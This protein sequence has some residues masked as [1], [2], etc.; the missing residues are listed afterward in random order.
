MAD[1]RPRHDLRR[2]RRMEQ[3]GRRLLGQRTRLLREHQL[4]RVVLAF[5]LLQSNQFQGDLRVQSYFGH[6]YH[7]TTGEFNFQLLQNIKQFPNWAI[8]DKLGVNYKDHNEVIKNCIRV[9]E[10]FNKKETVGLVKTHNMLF[11]FN[12]KF[13]FTNLENTLG[14]I[15]IVRDP[16]N[17]V[18]SYARHL[19]ISP[20]ETVKFMTKGKANDMFLMGNWAENFIS[21]KQFSN[22][23]KYLLIKYEDLENKKKSTLLK[24]FK[25]LQTLGVEFKFDMVKL[26]K[27]IK[28]T[29]FDK[30]KN[31]EKKEIFTESTIDPKTGKRKVFFNLGPKNDWRK[32]LDEKNR[33]IIEK[34]FQ[35]E[36]LEL[37]YLRL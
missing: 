13:P 18:L 10:S 11:N 6:E 34:N 19:K 28:A 30:M 20:E 24:V 12:G 5:L 3:V 32:I 14:V 15:Y 21:W 25:Y 23:N 4:P 35:K 31:L 26:N 37:G 29:E 22:Y 33:E 9:Q 1:G 16:R 2:Q 8:F 27:S 7:T 17:V 36:M